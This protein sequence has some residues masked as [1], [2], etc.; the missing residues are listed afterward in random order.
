M[1][2]GPPLRKGPLGLRGRI[3]DLHPFEV[4]PLG[5]RKVDLQPFEGRPYLAG[6]KVDPFRTEAPQKVVQFIRIHD[7][8]TAFGRATPAQRL[9]IAS[10]SALRARTPGAST[11]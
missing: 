1:F 10:R 8:H 3:N 9:S 11:R 7:G 4:L 5:G 2:V 6:R